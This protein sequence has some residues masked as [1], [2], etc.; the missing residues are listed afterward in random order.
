[1]VMNGPTPII[2]SML[3]DV[4]PTK[5]IPRT[6]WPEAAGFVCIEY[7]TIITILRGCS[8]IV[9]LCCGWLLVRPLAAQSGLEQAV[10]LARQKRYAEAAQAMQGVAI[11]ALPA[12]QIAFHRLKAAIASGLEHAAEAADEMDAALA[13]EPGNQ[14][15]ILADA[16]AELH[17]GRLDA[18]LAHARQVTNSAPVQELIGDIQEERREYV[19]AAKAYQAAVALAPDR[20]EYRI[21]LALELV[22][23]Y[24][25][26]PAIAVLQE[27]AP[28][29]PKSAR[30]RTLLGITQYAAGQP[31][32]AVA[33]LTEAVELDPTLE[34]AWSYLSSV[35][36]DSTA[37]PPP[38]T[39]SAICRW[40]DV[41]CGAVEL[42]QARE[43]NNA[44]LRGRAIAKLRKAPTE[45]PIARCELGRAYEWSGEWVEA[46]R[47]MEA[48]VAVQ[49]SAQNRYR[50]GLIY[51]ALGL[52]EQ[53][54]EQMKL[55][56]AAMVQTA[57]ENARRREA[58]QAFQYGAK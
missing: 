6:S 34:R 5:P 40:N 14:G 21:R 2:S 25:F 56:E 9:A 29:F 8:L 33:R 7:D 28:L 22:Q 13:I 48:C 54:R 42:R 45:N 3:A 32:D 23:H 19:E 43:Q 11:P 57:D 20:E 38:K 46:R 4:A 10:T 36:L 30:I 26:E 41:M 58:V 55:R 16:V 35:V 52:P 15:L 47:E 50:L 12:Q 51:S 44:A 39:T 18:A 31:G 49:A 27:A 37:A 1:M 17:A 53:A 24:T